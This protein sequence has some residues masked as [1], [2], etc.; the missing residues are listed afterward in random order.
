MQHHGAPHLRR[1]CDF[2]RTC[3]VAPPTEPGH[4]SSDIF[5]SHV[6]SSVHANN[7]RRLLAIGCPR[8]TLG[9][10]P[11][12]CHLNARRA[13]T[14]RAS[15]QFHVFLKSEPFSFR[16]S[17]PYERAC[18]TALSFRVHYLAARRCLLTT[19]RAKCAHPLSVFRA[20]S[21]II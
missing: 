9:P 6:H 19:G 11:T 7:L 2:G 13:T 14:P 16:T 12:T 3:M 21:N 4:G 17:Y 1:E 15:S 5:D 8:I 18:A 10:N 20:S